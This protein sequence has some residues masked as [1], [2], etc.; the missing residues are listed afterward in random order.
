MSTS[1]TNVMQ[2]AIS[3]SLFPWVTVA[4]W[5]TRLMLANGKYHLS[6]LFPARLKVL[7]PH[8]YWHEGPVIF[9]KVPNSKERVHE[10]AYQP[11]LFSYKNNQWQC[12][13]HPAALPCPATRHPLVIPMWARWPRPV[14][15]LSLA[16]ATCASIL[17]S[18]ELA[19]RTLAT[20]VHLNMD[21]RAW[22][23]L[24]SFLLFL[25]LT[26]KVFF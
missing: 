21:L 12:P 13:F 14:L 24:V 26:E 11:A 16:T 1:G 19:I 15:L 23:T 3:A 5:V 6:V 9:S 4:K 18:S 25:Q 17:V 10:G 8:L 22:L 2:W 7:M 20:Q